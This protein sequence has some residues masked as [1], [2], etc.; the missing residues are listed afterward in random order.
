LKV[1]FEYFLSRH[2]VR[3]ARELIGK[4]LYSNI[5]GQLTG[6]RIVETEAYSGAI[7]KASHAYRNKR[8]ARTEA[9]FAAGG[10]AYVYL[11][12]GIHH[13][14]NIVTNREG[15]PDAILIRALEP[16]AGLD[17]MAERRKVKSHEIRMTRGPGALGQAM[18]FHRSHTGTE[19]TGDLIWLEQGKPV[20]AEAI[21]ISKRIGVDYADQDAELPW[22]FYEAGNKYVSKP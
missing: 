20:P 12:Y 4:E 7:D 10:T 17:V 21:V 13:L 2:V 19:V 22:S 15:I 16:T 6:G 5:N 3:L 11:I 8:T 9:M 14:F 18:G 1:T